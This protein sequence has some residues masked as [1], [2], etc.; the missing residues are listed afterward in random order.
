[1]QQLLA[2]HRVAVTPGT[3]TPAPAGLESTGDPAF[4]SPWSYAGLPTVSLPCGLSPQ[5][6]PC[7]L[8][9]IGPSGQERLVLEVARWCEGI[10]GFGGTPPP[11]ILLAGR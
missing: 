11:D 10:L 2:P 8:Q 9:L 4:N 6:L 5:G 3:L 7:G 1:M